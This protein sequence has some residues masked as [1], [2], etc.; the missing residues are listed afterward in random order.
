MDQT[1]IVPL[2]PMMLNMFCLNESRNETG[3]SD[4]AEL[5]CAAS[6]RP[7]ACFTEPCHKMW[8][9]SIIVRRDMFVRFICLHVKHNSEFSSPQ[10]PIQSHL[11]REIVLRVH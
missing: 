5:F 6:V 2:V 10:V 7:F 1:N 3:N 4:M 8:V 11:L 9:V